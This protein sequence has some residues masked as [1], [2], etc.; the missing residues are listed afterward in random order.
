LQTKIAILFGIREHCN[1]AEMKRDK[2][3]KNVQ[4]STIMI[5]YN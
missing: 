4:S 5:M 1:D 3:A 2:P